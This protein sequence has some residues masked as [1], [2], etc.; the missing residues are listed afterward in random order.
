[1]LLILH[2]PPP[3]LVFFLGAMTLRCESFNSDIS[4]WSEATNLA[5][6]ALETWHTSV[7]WENQCWDTDHW[8]LLFSVLLSWTAGAGLAQTYWLQQQPLPS[9]TSLSCPPASLRWSHYSKLYMSTHPGGDIICKPVRNQLN[10]C[11]QLQM[12]DIHIHFEN[13]CKCIKVD[14]LKT[15]NCFH[16]ECQNFAGNLCTVSINLVI[17]I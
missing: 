5:L 15:Y 8:P 10:I 13:N 12:V 6:T 11:I 1:M 17:Q 3:P 4:Y 14:L 9:N 16:D 2:L 7:A